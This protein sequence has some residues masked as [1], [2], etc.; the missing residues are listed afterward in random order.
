ML[1]GKGKTL[2]VVKRGEVD[3]IS[4]ELS[5]GKKH[6]VFTKY[7]VKYGYTQ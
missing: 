6:C 4:A 1:S 2:K 5:Q 7:K 3:R